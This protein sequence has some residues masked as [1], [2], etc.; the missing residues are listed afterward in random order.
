MIINDIKTNKDKIFEQDD[1]NN[2]VIQP[3]Y[4]RG[5]L[6]HCVKIIL[7]YNEVIQSDLTKQCNEITNA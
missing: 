6:L 3:G 1:L 5:D 4:R 7:E 2:F